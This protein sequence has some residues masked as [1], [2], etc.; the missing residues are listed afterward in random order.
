MNRDV[1]CWCEML[2]FSLL[3]RSRFSFCESD[4]EWGDLGHECEVPV[5]FP[6][7][8][9]YNILNGP[10]VRWRAFIRSYFVSGLADWK[11]PVYV[12]ECPSVPT[13]RAADATNSLCPA[14]GL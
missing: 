9:V 6:P 11:Q 2:L 5:L 8:W 3:E 4:S 1:L 12:L 14:V 13:C 7:L 10:A